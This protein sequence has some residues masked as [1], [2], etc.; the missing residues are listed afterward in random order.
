MRGGLLHGRFSGQRQPPPPRTGQ[1]S[2]P[3][4]AKAEP[5]GLP[6]PVILL[7]RIFILFMHH[8]S[9]PIHCQELLEAPGTGSKEIVVLVWRHLMYSR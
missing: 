4:S 6:P 7:L 2:T 9:P 3:A 5:L 1:G 8:F